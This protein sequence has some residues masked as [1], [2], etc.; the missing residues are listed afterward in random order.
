MPALTKMPDNILGIIVVKNEK[1]WKASGQHMIRGYDNIKSRTKYLID[2]K[3][4][5]YSALI[6]RKI[7][8]P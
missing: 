6:N 1:V 3:S 2:K 7:L 8:Y 4:S 5:L